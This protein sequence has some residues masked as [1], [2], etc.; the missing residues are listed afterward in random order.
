[1]MNYRSFAVMSLA[2]ILAVSTAVAAAQPNDNLLFDGRDLTTFRFVFLDRSTNPNQTFVAANGLLRITGS[3][4]GYM[5]TARSYRNFVL[6]YD[7]R[8]T[9]NGLGPEDMK[10]ASGVLIH[11]QDPARGTAGGLWPPSIQ[12]Q[13]MNR[14]AAKLVEIGDQVIRN[15]VDDNNA[16]R[17]ALRPVGQWNATEVVSREGMLSTRLNGVPIGS[18]TTNLRSGPIGFQSEGAQ[19]DYANIVITELR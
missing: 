7:W 19:I 2:A 5:Y 18:C 9:P 17:R 14:E 8:Y 11:I 1:M 4:F 3:P 13:G 15:V 10:L 16:R 12:V 6:R